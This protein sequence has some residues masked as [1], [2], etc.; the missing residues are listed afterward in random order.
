[1]AL[2]AAVDALVQPQM[3]RGGFNML[4]AIHRGRITSWRQD[5]IDTAVPG[6]VTP[7]ATMTITCNG[8]MP[9]SRYPSDPWAYSL[10][11]ILSKG[12]HAVLQNDSLGFRFNW[13]SGSVTVGS[14]HLLSHGTSQV[15]GLRV[16]ICLG[17]RMEVI[18]RELSNYNQCTTMEYL[19]EQF[20]HPTL[21]KCHFL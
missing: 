3:F 19:L 11:L 15:T 6:W 13:E 20:Y 2:L 14:M 4:E 9:I 21:A 7:F 18:G 5:I 8:E 10:K 1:M 17:H 12:D 16:E